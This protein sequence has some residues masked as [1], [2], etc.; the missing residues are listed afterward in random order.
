MSKHLGVS[1][2]E[3]LPYNT[4]KLPKEPAQ[5]GVAICHDWVGVSGGRQDKDMLWKRVRDQ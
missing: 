1:G 2:K 5:G 3:K 4:K